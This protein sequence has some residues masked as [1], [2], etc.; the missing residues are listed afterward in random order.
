MTACISRIDVGA[1]WPSDVVAGLALGIGSATL[2]L[3]VR[4]LSDPVF[5]ASE[6][7]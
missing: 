1:H 2:F 6:A 5:E 7:V 4:R 3:S